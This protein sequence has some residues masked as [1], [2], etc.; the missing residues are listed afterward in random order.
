MNIE[1]NSCIKVG[2]MLLYEVFHRNTALT[3]ESAGTFVNSINSYY[4]IEKK[5]KNKQ[6][7]LQKLHSG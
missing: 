3:F 4:E 2:K 6:N 5:N 1:N 7:S